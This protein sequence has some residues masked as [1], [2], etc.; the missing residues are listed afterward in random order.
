M[1][2]KLNKQV[3]DK[4]KFNQTVDTSFNQLVKVPNPTFF[5]INLATINDFFILYN[6]FFY[7]IPKLGSS[8]SH[9]FLV[10]E[11]SDYIGS[12]QINDEIQALLDEI[13][14]LRQENLKI[15]EEYTNSINNLTNQF[16]NNK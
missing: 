1:K 14:Q 11:S 8:N 7:E 10:K 3:F 16:L 5:D 9:Q 4:E 15:N 6:K 12:S 13:T 2:I